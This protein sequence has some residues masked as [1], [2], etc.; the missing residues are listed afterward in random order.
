MT[1]KIDL[2]LD[3][4]VMNAAG[5]LGFA[6]NPRGLL[7]L[8]LFGAFVTNPISLAARSPASGRRYQHMAGGFLLHTGHPNPGLSR[9]IRQQRRSW[10]QASIPVIVHLLAQTPAE[11]SQMVLRLEGLENVMGI[12]LGLPPAID[13]EAAQALVQAAAG[14]LPII[15]RVHLEQVLA[16]ASQVLPLV[17]NMLAAGAAAISL[18]ALRGTLAQSDGSRFSGRLYG[19]AVFPLALRAVENLAAEGLPIIAAGGI[20]QPADQQAMLSAGAQAVQLDACL[21]RL[22]PWAHPASNP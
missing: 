6:P 16:E 18:G 4:P 17:E 7:D 21:W 19:P 11:V 12:E 9:V 10:A 8:N 1:A 22:P 14:E 20:Y 3:P 15:A 5:T 13:K 2:Y